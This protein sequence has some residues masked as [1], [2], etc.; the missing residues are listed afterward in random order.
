L[1][2]RIIAWVLLL[3]FILLIVNLTV[4]RYHTALSALVYM[5]IVGMFVLT[6][7]G[8]MNN[9]DK[10]IKEHEGAKNENNT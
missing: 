8:N 7:I 6:S 10:M 5:I 1:L 4:F 2:K 9:N 3:G